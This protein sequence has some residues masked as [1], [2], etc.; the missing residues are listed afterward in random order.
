MVGSSVQT[1]PE[2]EVTVAIVV[3]KFS[4]TAVEVDSSPATTLEE[5][6]VPE[7]E[8]SEIDEEET[9]STVDA[10]SEL[11]GEEITVAEADGD[12]EAIKLD[13]TDVVADE[14]V[15]DN[16]EE[17]DAVIVLLKVKL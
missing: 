4:T 8:A 9:G 11:D 17:A 5:S 1:W 14:E 15:E 16:D 3:C 10:V 12:S 6:P 2:H 7:I 13:K